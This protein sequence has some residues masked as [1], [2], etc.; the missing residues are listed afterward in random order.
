LYQ[1]L[2][3]YEADHNKQSMNSNTVMPTTSS[4]TEMVSKLSEFIKKM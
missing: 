3:C 1:Q 2:E 4:M